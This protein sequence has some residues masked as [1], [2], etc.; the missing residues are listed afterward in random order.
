MSA[1]AKPQVVARELADR[2]AA[3][4]LH[5]ALELC[6]HEHERPLDAGL[7]GG[8]ERKQVIASYADCLGAE[9]ERLQHV[10]A[11]SHATVHQYVQAVADRIHD[12][13]Q[14]I[15]GGARA[16]QLPTPV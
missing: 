14:L 15:E 5:V 2:S 12:F 4:Q 9:R 16:V 10:R 6:F 11:A 1:S 8:S 13:G 3:H 7:A